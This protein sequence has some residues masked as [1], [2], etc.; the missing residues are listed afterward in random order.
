MSTT[1][2][3]EYKNKDSTP[4]VTFSDRFNEL[5]PPPPEDG[6]IYNSTISPR[7]QF[8]DLE[9]EASCTDCLMGGRPGGANP[10]YRKKC[11]YYGI[12]VVEEGPSA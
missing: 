8:L 3:T 12:S 1:N 10:C 6:A 5:F 2:T 4:S 9:A 11:C 7:S